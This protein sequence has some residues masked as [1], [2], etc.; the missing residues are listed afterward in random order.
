MPA[1]PTGGEA[2][3]RCSSSTPGGARRRGKSPQEMSPP[4]HMSAHG[5]SRTARP[6]RHRAMADA[7][8]T[9]VRE[10]M[11]NET[12]AVPPWDMPELGA[13]RCIAHARAGA[14]LTVR[15]WRDEQGVK[16]VVLGDLGIAEVGLLGE[17]LGKLAGQDA[18]RV[19]VDLRR[20]TISRAAWDALARA[21]FD[22][23]VLRGGD[24][25]AR[26]RRAARRHAPQFA[27]AT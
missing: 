27:R 15:L 17:C 9:L 1:R 7:R 16:I 19:V 21:D 3:R 22:R 12:R 13:E 18:V 11:T 24:R 5:L 25:R 10:P 20:A 26:L 23:I 8:S 4:A 6:S 14:T 2:A